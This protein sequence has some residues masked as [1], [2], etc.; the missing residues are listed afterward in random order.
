VA[1][2]LGE[3]AARVEQPCVGVRRRRQAREVVARRLGIPK[4]AS[5]PR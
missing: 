3:V 1:T 5:A 2:A 4:P